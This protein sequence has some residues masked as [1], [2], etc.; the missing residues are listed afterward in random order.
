MKPALILAL[1]LASTE[2][3]FAADTITGTSQVRDA[4]TLAVAGARFR[5]DGVEPP[6]ADSGCGRASCIDA[7]QLALRQLITGHEVTCTKVRKLG[8]GYFMGRCTLDTGIQL[9]EWLLA[10]GFATAATSATAAERA[11]EL[12]ARDQ[13]LGIW[14]D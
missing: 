14:S 13:K 12:Y 3:V 2:P 6:A 10:N 5:L 11:A 7:A 8:H 1:M 4:S 9:G